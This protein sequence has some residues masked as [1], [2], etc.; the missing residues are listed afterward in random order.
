MTLGFER[1]DRRVETK[2]LSRLTT[3]PDSRIMMD[4][5]SVSC[6]KIHRKFAMLDSA[7]LVVT[8]RMSKTRATASKIVARTSV[9]VRKK[10]SLNLH[11][12]T[13]G[14]PSDEYYPRERII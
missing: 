2:R 11:G 1:S 9:A 3:M 4:M 12:L 5:N 8:C 7:A 13:L 10:V 6:P 14:R